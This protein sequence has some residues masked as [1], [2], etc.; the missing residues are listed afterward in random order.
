MCGLAAQRSQRPPPQPFLA[1]LD[2]VGADRLFEGDDQPGADRLDDGRGAALLP[3]DRVVEVAV[4][5]RVDEGDRAAAR[6]GRHPVAD[7]LAADDQDAGGLRAADELVRGQEDRVL[8]VAAPG[9]VSATRI[10]T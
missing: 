6:G 4:P 9:A 2:Q 5:D 3:G 10:G 7:Q 8:V 1:G